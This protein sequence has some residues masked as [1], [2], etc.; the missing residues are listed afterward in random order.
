[1]S[2][3]E[4]AT[5][6]PT[7]QATPDLVLSLDNLG[8]SFRSGDGDVAVVQD[9]TFEVPRS[10]TVALVGES[11]SGKSVSSLAMMGLLPKGLARI[12]SGT[13]QFTPRQGEP[14]IDLLRLNARERARVSG[15]EI[16]MIF[17]EP[18]TSLNPS[19]KIGEQ[20][21]E[22]IRRHRGLGRKAAD[23]ETARLLDLVGIPGAR[24]RMGEYPHN[25]SGG[26]RQRV[27]IA[28]ALACQPSL[29]IADEPTTALDVT[30]QAQILD[31]LREIQRDMQMSILFITH[32]LGVVADIAD[33]VVVLHGGQVME[34][35]P[36]DQLFEQPKHPYTEGLLG[37]LPQRGAVNGKLPSIPGQV[38][39]P[40][41][42][43]Q[44]CHFRGRCP[45]AQQA[46]AER[47]LIELTPTGDASFA[48]C[49]RA[50]ELNLEGVL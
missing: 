46:C 3:Q 35:A 31:L 49:I 9:V 18:M 29:L 22:I 50:E 44:G 36:V 48:R 24:R 25:F 39:Q 28:A 12:T 2:A 14:T 13:A 8:V 40:G 43:T 26:M 47:E 45:Y 30:V 27:M 19:M 1:M 20:I 11:G 34:Q 23:E 33:K 38:P 15:K 37:S 17:Q 41:T 21:A 32:D 7:A 6:E 5:V 16:S 42:V 4:H 10:K